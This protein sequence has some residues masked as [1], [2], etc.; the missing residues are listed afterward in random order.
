MSQKRIL[1][2]GNH[3]GA[4]AGLLKHLCMGGKAAQVTI[5]YI[6]PCDTKTLTLNLSDLM[7]SLCQ[8]HTGAGMESVVGR[9]NVKYM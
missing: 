2:P 8:A 4:T 7:Y 6:V 9:C 3:C 5:N 1:L